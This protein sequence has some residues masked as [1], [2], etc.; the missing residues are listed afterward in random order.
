MKLF[1]I[2]QNGTLEGYEGEYSNKIFL[3]VLNST[4]KFYEKSGFQLPWVCYIAVTEDEAV[5]TCAFKSVPKDNR[6]EIAYFTF[7]DYE[8]QGIATQMAKMLIEIAK[9]TDENVTVFAR[10]L[11]GKSASTRILE[12]LK[13]EKIKEFE[14]P[15]DGLIWEWELKKV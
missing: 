15:E 11:P 12:K 5:G 3:N 13:F 4:K 9:K 8:G 10:T 2:L 6:V 7:P 1:P 14:H